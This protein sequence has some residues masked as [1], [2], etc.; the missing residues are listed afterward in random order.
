MQVQEGREEGTRCA[1]NPC[2][3]GGSCWLRNADQVCVHCVPLGSL[4]VTVYSPRGWLRFG[5]Q[6]CV[7]CC[8]VFQVTTGAPVW[9]C[10]CLD[11]FKGEIR[12]CG[13]TLSFIMPT[14]MMVA[15]LHAVMLKACRLNMYSRRCQ[16]SIVRSPLR[17]LTRWQ[18]CTRMRVRP[19]QRS[20]YCLCM[21][22]SFG[23]IMRRVTSL[24]HSVC[25]T[26]YMSCCARACA[27]LDALGLDSEKTP[28]AGSNPCQHDGE[29]I[30][31]SAAAGCVRDS[32]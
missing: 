25:E 30:L 32:S 2:A 29:C 22:L 11:G 28:C 24:C 6:P 14:V 21:L 13:D 3:H 27:D 16:A 17:T 23:R 9:E 8:V 1:A 26:A 19:G 18:T 31:S 20:C 12:K 7:A 15:A 4:P 10:E 5:I